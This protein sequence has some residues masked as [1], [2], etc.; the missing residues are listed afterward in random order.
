MKYSIYAALMLGAASSVCTPLFAFDGGGAEEKSVEVSELYKL[1]GRVTDAKSGEVL[2]RAQITV[3]GTSIGLLSDNDGGFVINNL[4]RKRVT[5]HIRYTGYETKEIVVPADSKAVE[6]KLVP[7]HFNIEEV[8][9][10]ANR[11]ETRRHLAPVLVNVTDTKLFTATNSVSL[12]EALKFNPG[13]RV[14]DNCQNCGFNQV[15][16]N[17]LDGAY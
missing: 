7:S 8:V 16:I 9:V 10:S 15:R 1:K 5:L 11:T 12:D 17:G 3:M 14:E 13:V 6:I 2:P 4:P